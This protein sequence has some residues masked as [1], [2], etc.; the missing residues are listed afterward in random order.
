MIGIQVYTS[1]SEVCAGLRVCDDMEWQAKK[2]GGGEEEAVH[3]G[4]IKRTSKETELR[5][6]AKKI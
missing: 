3:Y 4:D 6:R 1:S 2:P 5:N